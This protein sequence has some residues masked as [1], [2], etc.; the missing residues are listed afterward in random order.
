MLSVC[1]QTWEKGYSELKA[2]KEDLSIL[3]L[4]EGGFKVIEQTI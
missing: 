1:T 2:Y 4:P 3:K